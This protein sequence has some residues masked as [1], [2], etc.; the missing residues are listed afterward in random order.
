M[1]L[2]GAKRGGLEAEGEAGMGIDTG[3]SALEF[4]TQGGPSVRNGYS[5]AGYSVAGFS[6]AGVSL[7]ATS[8]RAL[9][10]AL[11]LVCIALAPSRV[12]AEFERGDLNSDGVISMADLIYLIQANFLDSPEIYCEDAADIDDDGTIGLADIYSF[13]GFLYSLGGSTA[14]PPPYAEP[15]DDPTDDDL[16]PCTQP[17]SD[18]APGSDIEPIYY[19]YL[20]GQGL[21]AGGFAIPHGATE[22]SIPVFMNVNVPISGYAVSFAFDPT[23]ILNASIDF[24]DSVA[25][26]HGS[27]VMAWKQQATTTLEH[28]LLGYVVVMLT[29]SGSEAIEIP[30]GDELRACTVHLELSPDLAP[31]DVVTLVFADTPPLAAEPEAANEVVVP[32]LLT[33]YPQLIDIVVPVAAEHSM[34]LRG[35]VNRD[36][37]IGLV[38]AI[39]LLAHLYGASGAPL[40][41]ADAADVDDDGALALAD[42]MRILETAFLD[43]PSPAAPYPY[44]GVDV[45]PDLLAC[46]EEE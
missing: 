18:P 35:D 6:L 34:F 37:A 44:V 19:L 40:A 31:G 42:V 13:V 10:P 46:A 5:V 17:G 22:I 8:L 28:H 29:Y 21:G 43:G 14:L 23:K 33:S 39:T 7:A 20:P 15:G 30:A 38:D 16:A 11:L 2:V 9:A 1:G 26:E 27:D 24:N 32:S 12:H 41:C 36:E 4:S 25:D 3:S 45:G